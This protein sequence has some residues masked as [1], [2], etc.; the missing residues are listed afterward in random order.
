MHNAT[1]PFSPLFRHPGWFFVLVTVLGTIPLVGLAQTEGEL[2]DQINE[3]VASLDADTVSERD[4]AE[5][6]LMALAHVDGVGIEEFLRHLPQPHG[7]MPPAVQDRLRKIR[8]TL[9]E[10]LARSSVQGAQVQLEAINWKLSEV[11]KELEKQSGNQIIDGRQ[12]LNQPAEDPTILLVSDKV[13][14]WAALDQVLDE[15]KLGVNNYSSQGGISLIERPS[16]GAPRYGRA[17]YTG[18][19][20]CEVT[21][22]SA[23]RGLR[24]PTTQRLQLDLEI[25]WEPRLRPIAISQ[26]LDL[27]EAVD[28]SGKALTVAQ[29]GRVFQIEVQQGTSATTISLPFELPDR[30]VGAIAHL[31]GAMSALVAGQLHEFRFNNLT[32]PT[33]IT[34]SF[35]GVHVTLDRV[36]K[37][38]DLW[39]VHMRMKLEGDNHALESHR[40]WVFNNTNYLVDD[41]GKAVEYVGLET[42]RQSENEIGI[43]YIYEIEQ[44]IDK[45]AW[46]YESPVAIVEQQFEYELP[47]IPLP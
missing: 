33:P 16:G 9:E 46:V 35:G 2:E 12:Q 34:Q 32:S 4:L 45:L 21:E 25:A 36:V 22:V 13:P 24:L 1:P 47:A 18:P 14:F 27:V 29:P 19:F 28:E 8:R 7:N 26:P 3:L 6:N 43:A 42:T 5:T 44:P 39:E 41:T 11:L 20:R 31:R 40:G 38:N 23:I 37:N 15:V 17:S 10:E 30:S